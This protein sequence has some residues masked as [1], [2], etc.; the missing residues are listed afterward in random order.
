MKKENQKMQQYEIVFSEMTI[1]E[2]VG[3]MFMIG[4]K[5]ENL[6][7]DVQAFINQRNIGFVD[8]FA[9][10]VVSVEQATNL[11][12]QIHAQAKIPP[13]IFTDQEG[14]IVCQFAE[15]T[16]TFSSPMGLAA[17]CNPALTELAAERMGTDLSL[18]G[19]DGF[20]A[21]TIDVNR[22]P[23]NPIIGARSFSDDVQTVIESGRAFVN[24]INKSG[25]AAMPKHFPGHGTSKLDSHLVLPS[26]DC[27]QEYFCAYDLLPFKT[28]AKNVDFMMTAHISVPSI[29]PTGL[30]ATF[31]KI[32]LTD[33]LR[34][35]YGFEGILMSD[36]L[37]MGVIKNSYSPEEIL[38]KC[39]EAGVDVM[40]LSHSLDLQQELYRI[41]IEKV[42]NGQIKEERIN[43]SV[44]RILA[45][46]EKYGSLKDHKECNPSIA[47]I[48]VR[49][50]KDIEDLV[51]KNTIVLLRN[52]LKKLPLKTEQKI[53]IIE[54]DKTRS[55]V[56]LYE[57]TR[58]SYLEKYAKEYFR[59]V[60]VLLLPLKKPD[61]SVIKEFL[62]SCD[63]ILVA[64]FSRTPELEILQGNMI[65]EII[66]F[67]EDVIIIA[68]GNPYDIRNFP[69]AKTY[70]ATFGFRNSQMKALF[71]ILTGKSKPSGK[72]P[73]EIEGIFPRWY[74]CEYEA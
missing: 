13:M 74:R 54:W 20:I 64:P 40:L 53:G 67:R 50:K 29:D 17:T 51:C 26:I 69:D 22:E 19:V 25:L 68:T 36:C 32:F 9:R 10:N 24:G 6:P 49:N 34:N 59:E 21:P 2:K 62:Q 66:K 72:L 16:S 65:R 73:V 33:I 47:S 42:K 39:V 7:S 15:L 52:K 31:S 14:G 41:L 46:K 60:E 63:N 35:Q 23:N 5:E 71:D 58:C 11:M 12:N 4:F 56:Q 18:I 48:S 43:L 55:T 30:P 28:I 61:S 1:E 57:P 8:I 45:I 38:V 70:L 3:Q 27:S 37:E 44:K